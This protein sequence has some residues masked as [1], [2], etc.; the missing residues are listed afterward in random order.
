MLPPGFCEH[1]HLAPPSFRE[2]TPSCFPLHAAAWTTAAWIR[3]CVLW[4]SRLGRSSGLREPTGSAASINSRAGIITATHFWGADE[5]GVA[6]A[7]RRHGALRSLWLW[8]GKPAATLCRVGKPPLRSAWRGEPA[9]TPEGRIGISSSPL[10]SAPAGAFSARKLRFEAKQKA[11][12]GPFLAS[13]CVRLA[14][15]VR[16]LLHI[17]DL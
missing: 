9:A 8:R 1:S 14:S 5:E 2:Y 11:A 12:F 7:L 6:A 4:P 17:D 16:P 13:I 10:P 3:G 15:N